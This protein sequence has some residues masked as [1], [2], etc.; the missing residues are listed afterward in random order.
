MMRL[1]L[2]ICLLV[3]V[4]LTGCQQEIQYET[5]NDAG[6][7]KSQS[8]I[9]QA[10]AK[11][12]IEATK[13]EDVEALIELTHPRVINSM[14]GR[15]DAYF[16]MENLFEEIDRLQMKYNVF[17]H[18]GDP[19]F[20]RTDRHEFAIQK[21]RSVCSTPDLTFE[22]QSAIIGM[23]DLGSKE[24]K[25]LDYNTETE[26]LVYKIFPGLPKSLELPQPSMD[27]DSK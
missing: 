24:W 12:L 17:E 13:S 5:I 10:D 6:F 22:Q 11:A 27:V 19:T 9:V 16:A 8:A 18:Q 25:Y 20:Y 26:Q 7:V 3:S 1:S 2:P 23:R 15:A 14:G 21:L 4:T